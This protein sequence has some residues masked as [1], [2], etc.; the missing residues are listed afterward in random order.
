MAY[1]ANVPIST[2]AKSDFPAECRANWDEIDLILNRL[3]KPTDIVTSVGHAIEI[4]ATTE[5]INAAGNGETKAIG[6]NVAFGIPTYTSIGTT[7]VI[8]DA[9]SFRPLKLSSRNSWIG[10]YLSFISLSAASSA[11]NAST[12]AVKLR[13]EITISPMYLLMWSLSAITSSLSLDL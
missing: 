3:N 12:S 6:A 2:A 8:T 7:F 5:A 11:F 10:N 9:T 1:K 4:P 13:L